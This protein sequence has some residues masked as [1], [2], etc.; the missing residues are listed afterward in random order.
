MDGNLEPEEIEVLREM[1]DKVYFKSHFEFIQSHKGYRPKNVHL[2]MGESH[3]G[4]STLVRSLVMDA[5]LSDEAPPVLVWLSEET[6][7]E[8]LNE[9]YR[10]GISPVRSAWRTSVR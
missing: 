3:G 2:F 8:F 1:A 4:K 5:C 10:S 9:L 6:P 7:H